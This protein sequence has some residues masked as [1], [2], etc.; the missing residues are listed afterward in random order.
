MS[1]DRAARDGAIQHAVFM[2]TLTR[3]VAGAICLDRLT[4][5]CLRNCGYCGVVASLPPGMHGSANEHPLVSLHTRV[6]VATRAVLGFLRTGKR[7]SSGML[8]AL[9]KASEE[10]YAAI[11]AS[12][13]PTVG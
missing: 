6:H 12:G 5:D 11:E 13:L 8:P 1:D 7:P 2:N 9:A 3:L 10:L 4:E